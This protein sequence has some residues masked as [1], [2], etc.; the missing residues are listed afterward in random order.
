M[1]PHLLHIFNVLLGFPLGV[2]M[3]GHKEGLMA[4]KDAQAIWPLQ[5]CKGTQPIS[6]IVKPMGMMT[7][8]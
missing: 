5:L 6:L 2:L 8:W 1:S 4:C 3:Q 7:R